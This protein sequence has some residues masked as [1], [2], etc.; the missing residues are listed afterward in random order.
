M[1]NGRIPKMGPCRNL[2]QTGDYSPL[3]TDLCFPE[4]VIEC[5]VGVLESSVT[6]KQWVGIRVEGNR[7]IEVVKD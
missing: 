2:L 5:A 6:M 1:M 3:T 4:L 7:F